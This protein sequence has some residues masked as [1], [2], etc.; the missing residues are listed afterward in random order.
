MITYQLEQVRDV[1]D[2]AKVHFEAHWDEI[3]SNKHSRAFNPD[4]DL[5]LGAERRGNLVCAT[6]R[7]DGRVIG[8]IVW[9]VFPDPNAAPALTA[10]T[11][12]YYVED[13]PA[14]ARIMLK[15][16]KFSLEHLARLGIRNPRPRTKLKM[17]GRGRGAGRIWEALGFQPFE[18]IYTTTLPS[19]GRAGL[20]QTTVEPCPSVSAPSSAD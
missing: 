9:W 7:E 19:P 16:I 10:E 20:D 15:M 1:L 18:I 17:V 2:E 4:F 13:R 5:R 8:Y 3:A 11:D 6:A 14:R 12:I